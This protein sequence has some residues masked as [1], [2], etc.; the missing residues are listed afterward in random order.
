MKKFLLF[1]SFFIYSV[2]S[3]AQQIP[4]GGFEH[5]TSISGQFE[6]P[7]FWITNN[8]VNSVS[9][10][11]TTDSYSGNYAMQII[12]NGP[13]FE[14]PL[15]G[16]AL[17]TFSSNA[18]IFDFLTCYVKCDS[19]S[20]TGEGRIKIYGFLSGVIQLIGWWQTD[21]LIPQYTFVQVPMNPQ[22]NFD[23]IQINIE[24]FSKIDQLGNA[25]GYTLL[26]VD[27]LNLIIGTNGLNTND[28]NKEILIFPNPF[29]DRVIIDF[30]RCL[31]MPSKIEIYDSLNKL[32]FQTSI[33]SSPINLQTVLNLSGLARGKYT[34]LITSDKGAFVHQI[35]KQ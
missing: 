19:I 21:T 7:D 9:V 26:K 24:A 3:P 35:V 18:N 32:V 15:P 12:N 29:T 11:K 30:S 27:N 28:Y 23:S 20:G 8:A 13:S 31:K 1:L 25:S 6:E 4:N 5:W 16:Y 22:V 2:I 10:S 34:L 33:S 14:G 17:T